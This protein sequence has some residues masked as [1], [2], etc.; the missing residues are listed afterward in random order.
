MQ[1]SYLIVGTDGLLGEALWRDLKHRDG[2][3]S[4]HGTSRRQGKLAH[5][6]Y[7]TDLRVVGTS[8]LVPDEVVGWARDSA[9]P[10]KVAFLVAAV[11]GFDQCEA[12]PS[13]S[14]AINVDAVRVLSA[15]FAGNGVF[16]VFLSSSA[17]FDP[18]T[19]APVESSSRSPVSE[20][21]R[22]KSEAEILFLNA[23][24]PA[25]APGC[26]IVRLTKVLSAQQPLW[27]GWI[28]S[29]RDGQQIDAAEDLLIS[30]LSPDYVVEGLVEIARLRRPGTYHLSGEGLVSY[31]GVATQLALALGRSPSQ[32]VPVKIA[33]RTGVP[34]AR[35]AALLNMTETLATVGIA[36]QSLRSVISSLCEPL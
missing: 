1:S 36:P 35:S 27:G 7:F 18:L 2:D 6:V 8:G 15:L 3:C 25:H 29:L 33:D 17:V 21:G 22:Q 11:T 26:A 34:P 16:T 4:T 14:R 19:G 24:Q 31:H 23:P 32:V 9:F 30:P 10:R 5:D 20:Y 28:S 13:A 12:E